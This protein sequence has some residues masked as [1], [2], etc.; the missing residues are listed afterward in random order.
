MPL[1]LFEAVE[2]WR[3]RILDRILTTD[4]SLLHYYDLGT[5]QQSSMWTVNGNPPP[6]KAKVCKSSGKNMCIMFMDRKST[7]IC[8]LKHA[9]DCLIDATKYFYFKG[10]Q[11]RSHTCH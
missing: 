11:A 4:E 7:I 10:S 2:R 5:K 8:P 9:C 1:G 3:G 6:K